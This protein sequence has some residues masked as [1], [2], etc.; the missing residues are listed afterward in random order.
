[1]SVKWYGDEILLKLRE[2]AT[3]EMIAKA[4]FLIEAQA[5]VNVTNNGQ[6]DTGFMRSSIY[7]NTPLGNTYEHDERANPMVEPPSGA[8]LVA[9]AAEYGIFQEARIPFLYPAAETV[10]E[11]VTAEIVSIGREALND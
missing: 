8:G 4:A 10:A 2:K 9:V 1:M 6:V 7:A 11:Q 5:K 3:P